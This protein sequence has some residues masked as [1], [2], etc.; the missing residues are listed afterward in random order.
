MKLARRSFLHLAA[1]SA[2]VPALMLAASAFD[3]PTR[4][5]HL[6]VGFPPG[7]ARHCGSLGERSIG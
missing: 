7:T 6:V 2:T 5:A 3:Y 4:P 1:N